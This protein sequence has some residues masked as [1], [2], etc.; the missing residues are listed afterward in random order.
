MKI[1]KGLSNFIRLL[2]GLIFCISLLS[3]AVLPNIGIAIT[4]KKKFILGLF[5]SIGLGVYLLLTSIS[6]RES[7]TIYIN[8]EKFKDPYG[9]T[10]YVMAFKISGLF[11]IIFP[12]LFV[13][14]RSLMG[15]WL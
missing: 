5:M 1:G 9:L 8:G 13:L 10:L 14:I 15:Y 7:K 12:I 6:A 3:I 2:C 11:L 4:E